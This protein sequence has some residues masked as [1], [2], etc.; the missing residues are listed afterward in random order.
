MFRYLLAAA[1]GMTYPF[2]L[3]W[4]RPMRFAAIVLLSAV[5][6][7]IAG[8]AYAR[9]QWQAARD[10]LAA[11]LAQDARARL[12]FPLFVWRW[13]PD[14]QV[15]AAR[16]ARLNGDLPAAEAYLKRSTQLAGG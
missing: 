3:A 6:V 15:L 1:R 16:A 10:A 7:V 5:A 13:D 11:E 4:R 8:W 9:H 12:E 2:R 14:V